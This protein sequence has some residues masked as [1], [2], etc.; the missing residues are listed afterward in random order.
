LIKSNKPHNR[1]QVLE[2]GFQE[3]RL[4]ITN[5]ELIKI[6]YSSCWKRSGARKKE[7]RKFRNQDFKVHIWELLPRT[8]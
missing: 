8:N 4:A 6:R 3:L 7:S 2:F 1:L 5:K